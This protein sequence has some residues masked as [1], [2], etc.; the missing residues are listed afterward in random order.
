MYKD[1]TNFDD[2]RNV[3]NCLTVE[4][5]D[6]KIDTHWA[7]TAKHQGT[8][9]KRTYISAFHGSYEGCWGG[10][11][12]LA[13]KAYWRESFDGIMREAVRNGYNL[14]KWN[15]ATYLQLMLAL[16]YSKINGKEVLGGKGGSWGDDGKLNA[17]YG[18]F[19]TNREK[20]LG[21]G[22]LDT[23][24]FCGI[25]EPASSSS[26]SWV[27]G[28]QVSD[29]HFVYKTTSDSVEICDPCLRHEDCDSVPVKQHW[30]YLNNDDDSNIRIPLQE[31][32]NLDS[33]TRNVL[34]WTIEQTDNPSAS[35][36]SSFWLPKFF[37]QSTLGYNV[38]CPVPEGCLDT[39]DFLRT[40]DII[41]RKHWRLR[42]MSYMGDNDWG[43]FPTADIVGGADPNTRK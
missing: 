38:P 42:M 28:I 27:E 12:S 7:A 33:T 23:Y 25:L 30:G 36:N 22:V 6:R 17:G 5:A 41:I 13:L 21:I 3:T 32:V 9:R 39:T 19:V 35:P 2:F 11:R 40:C 1:I 18:L 14:F 26:G 15:H 20:P 37:S 29:K 8:T 16:R 34:A 31:G 43:F 4:V 24:K 10:M